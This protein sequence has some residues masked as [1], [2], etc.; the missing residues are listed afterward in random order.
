[1]LGS[2]ASSLDSRRDVET[3]LQASV[4]ITTYNRRN[5]L[6]ETVRALGKQSIPPES[7]EIIVVDDGSTDGTLE[8]LGVASL[9]CQVRTLGTRVNRGISAGRNL[10]IQSAEGRYLIFVSDDLIVPDDFVACHVATLERFPGHWVVG[11]FRQL[12]SLRETP[13]GR[14]LDDLEESF[15][16]GRKVALIRPGIWE[17]SWPTARNLSLPR[18]DLDRT[19]LFDERFHVACEDQDLAHRARNAGIRFLYNEQITCVHNDQVGDLRRYCLAQIPRTRDTVLFCA[20]YPSIHG[21]AN[22]TR[23]NG[24]LGWRDGPVLMAKK[25]TK[26]LLST[27]AGVALVERVVAIGER[28]RWP[29]RVLRRLYRLLIGLNM[30]RGWREGLR[31]LEQNP[32]A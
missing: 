11:G 28:S 1:M 15:T 23:V 24:Y 16:E 9:P 18:H 21:N 19:G 32:L 22:V 3:V 12:R 30:F 29:E 14:Y 31:L 6:L 25:L 8:A 7:Y 20:K 5:A 27:N 17:I 2:R 10:G 4:I 13:F 26:L